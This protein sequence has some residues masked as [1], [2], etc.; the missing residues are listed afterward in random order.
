MEHT[1]HASKVIFKCNSLRLSKYLCD[2]TLECK[3]RLFP[4]HRIVLAACSS[5]FE[6]GLCLCTALLGCICM[7]GL[8][9]KIPNARPPSLPSTCLSLWPCLSVCLSFSRPFLI[10]QGLFTTGFEESRKDIIKLRG[11]EPHILD[12]LLNFAYTGEITPP[13]AH[14]QVTYYHK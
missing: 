8:G 2:V 9:W 1:A 3:G 5:Y 12:L 10:T 6:V 13:I 7:Y 14:L 11:L 4:C